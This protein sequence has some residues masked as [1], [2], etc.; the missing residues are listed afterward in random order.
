MKLPKS[1]QDWECPLFGLNKTFSRCF[2]TVIGRSWGD[3][4]E[5]EGTAGEKAEEKSIPMHLLGLGFTKLCH[6]IFYATL[7][8]A[9]GDIIPVFFFFFHQPLYMIN[10]TML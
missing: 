2:S 3:S 10:K 4:N 9:I 1:S 8:C 6:R 5:G 7:L